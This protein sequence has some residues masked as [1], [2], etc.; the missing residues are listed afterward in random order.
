MQIVWQIGSL[1]R[2]ISGVNSP[3]REHPLPTGGRVWEA[4]KFFVLW[5][6]NGVFCEFWGAKFKVFVYFELPQWG[7]GLVCG[8]LWILEQSNE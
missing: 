6:Q 7:L 4:G 1:F 5:S 3:H 2:L 8:K